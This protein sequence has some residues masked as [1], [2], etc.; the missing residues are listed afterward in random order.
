MG[1]VCL[2]KP[3]GPPLRVQS[4]HAPQVSALFGIRLEINHLTDFPLNF[5]D[6]VI[7]EAYL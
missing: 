6:T 4:G 1:H 3:L 7:D 2:L 5:L